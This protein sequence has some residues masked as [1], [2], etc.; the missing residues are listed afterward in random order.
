VKVSSAS[1]SPAGK[2]IQA[3]YVHKVAESLNIDLEFEDKSLLEMILRVG[4]NTFVTVLEN[5]DGDYHV[6]RKIKLSLHPR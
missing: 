6:R 3:V 1:R 4:F 5:K 2:P